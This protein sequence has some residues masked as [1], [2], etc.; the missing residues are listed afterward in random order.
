MVMLARVQ[1]R[2]IMCSCLVIGSIR[3]F[4]VKNVAYFKIMILQ[5]KRT[6]GI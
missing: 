4:K 1:D 3:I 2:Q 5:D 6:G